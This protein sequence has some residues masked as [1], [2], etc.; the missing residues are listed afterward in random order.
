MLYV[1]SAVYLY[2]ISQAFRINL[3]KLHSTY[4]THMFGQCTYMH[5]RCVQN[6]ILIYIT[7]ILPTH[8]FIL[9]KLFYGEFVRAL[10]TFKVYTR[11]YFQPSPQNPSYPTYIRPC[12]TYKCSL[13]CRGDRKYIYLVALRK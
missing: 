7:Y 10:K 13:L 1:Y 9:I 8:T 3:R 2:R 11:T 6:K 4:N 5:M 12:S